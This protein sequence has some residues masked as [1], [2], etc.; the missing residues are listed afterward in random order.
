MPGINQFKLPLDPPD[1]G[2]SDTLVFKVPVDDDH[3][4]RYL[5]NRAALEGAAARDFE[6]R[7]PAR[8]AAVA[9]V[10]ELG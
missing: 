4:A 6:A 3:V 1:S 10:P 5:I 8:Q 7:G 2:W 9:A